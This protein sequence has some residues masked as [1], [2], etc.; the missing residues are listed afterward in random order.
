MSAATSETAARRRW[1]GRPGFVPALFGGVLTLIMVGIGVLSWFYLPDDINAISVTDRLLP[2]GSPGH[3]FGTDALGRDMLSELMVGIRTSFVVGVGSALGGLIVGA[4]LG[5]LAADRAGLVSDV[6][7]RGVDVFLAIPG[8]V[9]ALVLVTSLGPSLMTTIVALTVFFAP[10]IARIT[11]SAA[12]GVLEEDFVLAAK[13]HGRKRLFILVRHVVPNVS[14]ML[15]VQGTIYLARG[16]LIEA[17][18]SYLG[19]GIQR[20]DISLGLLIT[21]IQSQVGLSTLAIVWPGLT[22]AVLVLGVNALGDA[23][24]DLFDPKLRTGARG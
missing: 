9:F 21:E 5:L 24:R 10:A 8:I 23:L 13:L 20:P 19:A 1:R 15:L 11:R 14:P 22:I 16:V 18:L 2:A 4:V 7:M 6:L 3:I 17:A 12:L